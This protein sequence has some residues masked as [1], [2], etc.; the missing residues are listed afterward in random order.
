VAIIGDA[1]SGRASL[2]TAL[3][4]LSVPEQGSRLLLNGQPTSSMPLHSIRK[5][6]AV[7]S[8]KTYLLRGTLR[9]NLDPESRHP[10]M[11]LWQALQ[12]CGLFDKV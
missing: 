7:V 4:R 9:L 2:L 11:S 6:V 5:A 3:L 12:V 1:G 10:D 8:R